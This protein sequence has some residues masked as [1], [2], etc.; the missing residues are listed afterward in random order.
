MA[1]AGVDYSLPSAVT[2]PAGASSQTI[3]LTP[4][5]NSNLLTSVLAE[6]S[7]QPGVG[8]RLSG[9]SAASIVIFPAAAL[10]GTGLTGQYFNGSST[11]YADSLNFNPANLALTSLDPT[12][13]FVWGA[14]SPP[15]TNSG[16]YTVRWSG[17]VQPQYSETYTFIARTG[18]GAK[19]W[20]DDHLL[21]DNW[22]LQGPTDS[23]GSITLLG[24]VRYNLR[25]EYFNGSGGN[26]EAHLA[27]LSPSQPRQI[28]PANRLYP[29]T[30]AISL[31]AIDS[32]FSAIAFQWQPFSYTVTAANAPSIGITSSLPPGLVFNP[33]NGVIS[34]I[35]TVAGN[36]QIILTASNAVGTS[37]SVLALNVGGTGGSGT[38]GVWREVWTGIAGLDVTN[39]PV[40]TT[41]TYT[42]LLGGLEGTTGSGENYGE[43]LRGYLT[44]PV[45]GNYYFWIAASDSAELWIS[46]DSDPINKLLRAYVLPSANPAPPP[47]HGTASRQWNL[48]PNQKSPWL[49]LAAGEL[50]YLEILHKAGLGAQDNFAVGW[51]QDSTGTNNTPSGVIP[52]SALTPYLASPL[53]LLSQTLY[54]ANLLA[55]NGIT[56]SGVGSATLQLSAD[57]SEAVLKFSYTGLSSAV[58]GQHIH[59]DPYFGHPSQIMFDIDQAT[60]QPDGSYVWPIAATG[61]LSVDDILEIIDEGKAYINIH[62]VNYPAGEINGHFVLANGTRTFTPPP[63]PPTWTDDHTSANAAA[64]FLI[65][66]TYGPSPAEIANV[67]S[68]GYEAW[69]NDQFLRPASPPIC[70]WY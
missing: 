27:W 65:Q 67:Q 62:T 1:T 37:T 59:N 34:G 30:A 69:I 19:L 28:I 36:Y 25:L 12:I 58:T 6:V 38:A 42:T 7:L 61:S 41:A 64:R 50:Y 68:M 57:E 20:V 9:Q 21:I 55:Q 23:D 10:S 16:G 52:A 40:D 18:D 31:A 11:N 45:S 54:T 70:R 35:P 3:T 32:P 4:L 66:A 47:A 26:G 44:V 33:T 48:Q 51:L 22:T 15:I 60:P 2:I 8:Y 13:D 29:A 46:N 53:A 49:A 5:A 63:P 43:R 56:S 14:A 39:I 17:Q 24:G